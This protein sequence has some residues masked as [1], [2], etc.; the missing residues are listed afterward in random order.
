MQA[1]VERQDQGHRMFG[2]RMRGIGRDSHH[3]QAQALRRRQVDVVVAGRAQGDQAGAAGGQLFQHRGT[4]VV[5]D[6]GT[7]HFMALGQGHGVQA[8]AGGLELQFDTR[9]QVGA[10]KALTVVVLAAE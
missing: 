2:N 8:Q 9:R 4:Q 10:E 7:D 6:E 1:S 3:V 5:V